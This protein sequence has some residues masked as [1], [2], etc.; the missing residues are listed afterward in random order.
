M[1][2]TASK[3]K[4]L[5]AAIRVIREKGYTATRVEDICAAAKLTKGSFFHHFKTKEDLAIAAADYW[6]QWTGE[7]FA[8][9]PFRTL[10]D[11]RDRVL[12]YIEFRKSILEGQ[13]VAEFSCL[14]G[15]MLQEIYEESPAI[16]AACERSIT[17]HVTHL[18]AELA[19]AKEL[20]APDADWYPM[21]LAMH[22]Q[23]VLQGAFVLSKAKLSS[24]VV[25][26]SIDHLHRYITSLLPRPQR[27]K[28][29]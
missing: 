26:D 19:A 16:R 4:L 27:K 10:P 14:I 24:S 23:A 15:T 2:Q 13:S 22:T 12:G 5:D 21:S 1:E 29:A 7:L 17:S 28:R 3:T 11:P 20:Y 8:D 9:A 18:S 25:A 6:T